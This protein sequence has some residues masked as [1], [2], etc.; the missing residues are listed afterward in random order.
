MNFK[1]FLKEGIDTYTER[2][3]IPLI[4]KDCKKF[5]NENG[6]QFLYRGMRLH[7]SLM[8]PDVVKMTPRQDRIPKDTPQRVQ[9]YFNEEFELEYGVKDIRSRATFCTGNKRSART[10][11]DLYAIFP[12]GDYTYW[13][14]PRVH[15]FYNDITKYITATYQSEISDDDEDPLVYIEDVTKEDIHSFILDMPYQ[16]S[17]LVKAITSGYEIMLLCDS[18]Y[19]IRIHQD[20]VENMGKFYK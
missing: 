19:A 5:L 7:G 20:Y 1:Q 6:G 9:K 17:D 3:V 2:E 8:D 15:D 12:M 18:Y 4:K 14:S 11:G 16:S 13:W 10:Y